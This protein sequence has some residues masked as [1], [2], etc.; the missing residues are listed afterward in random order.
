MAKAPFLVHF[1]QNL[2][3]SL[4]HLV[5]EQWGLKHIVV[6]EEKGDLEGAFGGYIDIAIFDKNNT[7]SIVAIE[8]E[9]KS[10]YLQAR[11][12]IEKLKKWSHNSQYR[13]CSLLQVFN[14]DCSIKEKQ[15]CNLLRFAKEVERKGKGFYYDF[16]FFSVPDYRM[17]KTLAYGLVDS[18]DFRTRL[19]NLL[20][21]A[22]FT[23]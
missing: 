22:G 11:T 1:Q 19:R 14:D 7:K 8:I 10:S 21:D 6:C 4:R 3:E 18:L 20:E 13:A 15:I 23:E 9:N 17:K 5:Q 12:N 16:A 2:C